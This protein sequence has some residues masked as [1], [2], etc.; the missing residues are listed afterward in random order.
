MATAATKPIEKSNGPNS[1]VVQD[2]MEFASKYEDCCY[3][4]GDVLS[5]SGLKD[6]GGLRLV[7]ARAEQLPPYDE[8][9]EDLYEE[10]DAEIKITIHAD[11]KK[12]KVEGDSKNS[13]L[14]AV[15]KWLSGENGDNMKI[16]SQCIVR[17]EPAYHEICSRMLVDTYLMSDFIGDIKDSPFYHNVWNKHMNKIITEGVCYARGKVSDDLCKNL[18]EHI[19]ELAAKTQ[20]DYHPKSNDIVRDLVHPALYPY[21]KGESKLKKNTKLPENIVNGE[22]KDFWGR[23]YERSKFQ[24]LPTTFKITNER[25]CLIQDYIN[26]LDQVIFSS[27]YKDLEALFEVF[28]PFFEEVWSY[29]KAMEFFQGDS[30]DPLDEDKVKQFKKEKVV[31][32][33][34]ELQVIT[35]IVDYTLKPDQF[36]EGVWHAE[37]MSHE[38]IVMTGMYIFLQLNSNS[39][40]S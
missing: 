8:R 14:C 2:F 29:A 10:F 19:G 32:A 5:F 33:G 26:N 17:S 4:E 20:V 1:T 34:K 40:I 12:Y 35:K 27:L 3:I 16:L 25:K 22:G 18:T 31:F 9:D 11:A 36:Y 30:D 28:L 7:E 23:T 13:L 37:G 15:K 21:I 38:N 39:Q 6:K 24:W